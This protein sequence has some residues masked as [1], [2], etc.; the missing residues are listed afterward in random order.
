MGLWYLIL[1]YYTEGRNLRIHS[2][3][4]VYRTGS[5]SVRCSDGR[6]LASV[7]LHLTCIHSLASKPDRL[8]RLDILWLGLL[9]TEYGV[10]LR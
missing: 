3:Q 4:F 10:D 5:L 2:L 9:C 1:E 8:D 7:A 6:P